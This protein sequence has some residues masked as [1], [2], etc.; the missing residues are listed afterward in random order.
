MQHAVRDRA[1]CLCWLSC[2]L[3]VGVAM[4]LCAPTASAQPAAGDPFATAPNRQGVK[5]SSIPRSQSIRQTAA[6]N[7]DSAESPFTLNEPLVEVK[8]E[9]NTTIP[10]SEI[11][12]HIKT[13]PGRPVTA[14]QIK[15]DV[16]DLVRTRWFANVEPSI[17]RTD[18]GNV[19]VFRVLERPIVT[20]VEFKGNKKIKTKVFQAMT[21]LKPGS[22]YDVSANR[23]CARRIEEHYHEK[24]YNFATVELERG[25]VRNDPDRVV[26]FLISE[27]PKVSVSAV[28]FEGNENFSDG[29]LKL[30]TRT[31]T[32]ILWLFGG[33]YDPTTIADD[34]EGVRQY[35][36]SLGYFD[37]QVKPRQEFSQDKSKIELHYE[38]SEG[39][40]YRIR[41]I[42]VAGNQVLSEDEIRGMTKVLV[43][44]EYNARHIAKD[45]EAIKTK[46]GEQGRLHARVDAVPVW[47]DDNDAAV[48]DIVYKIDE[49]KVYRIRN[50]DVHIAGDHPHTKTN[51]IRNLSPI[52]PGDLADPKKI[53]LLKRRL[54]GSQYFDT[55]AS[56]PRID[57]SIVKNDNWIQ[58]PDL[59]VARGQ[60]FGSAP[61]TASAS[62]LGT[63]HSL[64]TGT[65]FSPAEPPR[66]QTPSPKQG[67]PTPGASEPQSVA[68]PY[69]VE[70]QAQPELDES[71]T[72]ADSAKLAPLTPV[73]RAQ[74][75]DPLKPPAD[76]GFDNSP[77]GD[78]F[79]KAIRNPDPNDWERM[80]RIPPP[81]FIDIDTYVSEARTGRLMF[82]VGVNSDAG[83]VGNIVLS[84]QNFDILRPP[85]SWA[86][87][88]N[89]TAW[90]GGGQRFRV[91]AMPGSSVSRYLVDWSDP[92]F[93]D[94]NYN[95]GV[96]GFYFQRFYTNWTE[97]RLGGRIRVGRQFTQRWSGAL[98]LRLE[99][100]NVSHPNPL[101]PPPDLTKVLGDTY[102]STLRASVMHDS[103]DAAFL[104]S[105]GHYLE[106][107]V[108]QA[109]NQ[110][111]YTRLEA[112]GR[113]YFTTY[114]RAD[115]G[116]RH[117][118][119][120]RGQTSWTGADTPIYER[121]YAGGFQTFR[122]F[123]FR[124]VSPVESNVRV[125]GNWMLLGG[126]EYMLPVTANE[127]IKTVAFTDFGT[128]TDKVSFDNFRLSVGA[129]LRVT[130]PAMG[131]V[132]IALDFA[133]PIMH[134]SFDKRQV[135]S[136]YVGIN[137]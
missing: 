124:G 74:S 23:E 81:E 85:T 122:G 21:Q 66:T 48:V 33:K 56:G 105:E 22:P 112:E 77:Q 88:W 57:T 34:M 58:Q 84:E 28:R 120:F 3:W 83:V 129:G 5:L 62:P 41:N 75:K 113:Q 59:S 91:E 55:G 97:E 106:L 102:L 67:S 127:M 14:K 137:R 132:P 13:R 109:F 15:D 78:P 7:T 16:D 86:D 26:I 42:D 134:E 89:G 31:K 43:G 116:G 40:R 24:G 71:T 53:Y 82:G 45:V 63:G 37:V 72:E 25:D 35:Y 101:P 11:A 32:R 54:E 38:I 117:T 8:I 87:V 12:R 6:N 100:V 133:Y 90:R 110:F 18:D 103:R 36:Y 30:K 115:G 118:L 17:R 52:Q 114:R 121:F 61:P 2:A 79:G 27:G 29:I 96:S 136:F 104:P 94:T 135:F 39:K 125:G 49:D 99:D 50:F 10:N 73:F 1:N 107:S 130:V 69:F 111:N 128:V 126:A 80:P 70:M 19:L 108:E 64:L 92:Y 47:T 60:N 44:Q 46:Y 51:L 76:F 98:A 119:T 65:S 123:A 131:P 95:L 93:M 20:K 68:R 4:G 9:G